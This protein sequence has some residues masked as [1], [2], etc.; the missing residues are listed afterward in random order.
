MMNKPKYYLVESSVMPAILLKVVET[1]RLLE[2]GRAKTVN[3]AVVQTGISRS[4]YYKYKDRVSP[5]Y[6]AVKDKII[7]FYAVLSDEPGALSTLLNIFAKA[8]SNILTINQNIPINGI[9]NITLTIQ[10]GNLKIKLDT[11]LEKVRAVAGVVSIEIM[12]SE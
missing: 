2:H 9:A 4:A 1:K 3:E 10:T 8:G 12:A 11:L 7:T 5:F 6:E